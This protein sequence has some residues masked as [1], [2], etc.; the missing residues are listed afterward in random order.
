[1][2]LLR[3][4]I[5]GNRCERFCHLK[6]PTICEALSAPLYT[7]QRVPPQQNTLRQEPRIVGNQPNIG[8][9][10]GLGLGAKDWEK[11]VDQFL[12]DGKYRGELTSNSGIKDNIAE[13]WNG[14][15]RIIESM[16]ISY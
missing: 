15:T 8:G 2:S 14:W 3:K 10:K 1:M 12:V 7:S 16:E 13:G 11:L 6:I 9:E 5:A 4:K